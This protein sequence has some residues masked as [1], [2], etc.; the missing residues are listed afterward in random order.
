LNS[1]KVREPTYP[2]YRGREVVV[3]TPTLE[4]FASFMNSK[5]FPF[6]FDHA[7]AF[8][9]KD[10]WNDNVNDS[11]EKRKGAVGFAFL[12]N[13]CKEYKYS[14]VEDIGSFSNINVI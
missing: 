9:N 13:I 3:A 10:L 5:K 8:I 1:S 6:E 7:A 14:I 11:P 2:T 12:R 4:A